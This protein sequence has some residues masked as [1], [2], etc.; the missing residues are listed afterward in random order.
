M[1]SKKKA[2]SH[3]IPV[4]GTYR[5]K[6]KDPAIDRLRTVFQEK[7]A[8]YDGVAH[9]AG[10]SPGTL[11]NWFEGGTRRPQFATLNAAARAMGYEFALRRMR[12]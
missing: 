8:T 5:F 1:A 11:R 2:A 7:K 10:L 12:N 3:D 6:D 9:D 4:Y